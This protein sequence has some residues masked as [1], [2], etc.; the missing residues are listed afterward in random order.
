MSIFQGQ[1]A[2][3]VKEDQ[4]IIVIF[5][6]SEGV[7]LIGGLSLAGPS[8]NYF[9]PKNEN[10]TMAPMDNFGFVF[11]ILRNPP[12]EIREIV[13][14]IAHVT[15]VVLTDACLCFRGSSQLSTGAKTATLGK[16]FDK[17]LKWWLTFAQLEAT[18]GIESNGVHQ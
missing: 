1:S 17:V 10:Y 6:C 18:W 12:M 13:G 14:D 5:I 11:L 7:S 15:Q 2:R 3:W 8:S 16:I 9:G 4:D